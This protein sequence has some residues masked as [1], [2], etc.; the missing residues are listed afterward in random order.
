MP[1][2]ANSKALYYPW[3][4]IRDDAWL[5]T[6]F[7]YWNKLH[8][9][10][11]ESIEQPYSTVTAR[12]LSDEDFLVPLHVNPRMA[13][14]EDLGQDV[15]DY[16]NTKEGAELLLIDPERSSQRIHIEKL[17][18]AIQDINRIHVKKLPYAISS[19]L[20]HAHDDEGWLYVD[21]RF[22]Q[23][24]MT[25]LANRLCES[26]GASLVT[27]LATAEQLAIRARCD[28]QIQQTLSSALTGWQERNIM[29]LGRRHRHE[30]PRE[31]AV[32][33]IAQLT[34]ERISIHPE[35]PIEK[36]VKFKNQ[37]NDEL[38]LFRQK[39][40]TLASSIDAN[41][42]ESALRQKVQDIY[43]HEVLPSITNLKK[44]LKGRRI[45]YGTEG[46]LKV[47]CLSA[48]STSLLATLGL[49]VP[50]ALLAGASLSLV[51][52]GTVYSLDKAESL[53]SNPFSYLL[54]LHRQFGQ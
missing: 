29:E 33:A 2:I 11:P 53:R 52:A 12:F 42:S 32:G 1:T 17:P 26:V 21:S 31:V 50:M 24:Y 3:I 16:L 4:D 14:I 27:P 10:V 45:K 22:A 48:S 9:I 23:F 15:L 30:F 19:A 25:L 34:I 47:S 18:F 40:A 49:S 44:A 41:L 13:E 37:Y 39:I 54:S 46:L 5:K 8:T 7:L 35:V 28:A 43:E 38:V 6:A 20:S 51:A 36:I